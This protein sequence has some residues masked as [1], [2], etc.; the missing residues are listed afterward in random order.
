M[1]VVVVVVVIVSVAVVVVV[2]V[3]NS[4]FFVVLFGW[5]V[6]ISIGR[7]PEAT[8]LTLRCGQP[9]C[10]ADLAVLPTNASASNNKKQKKT[11]KKTQNAEHNPKL[12]GAPKTLNLENT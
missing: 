11:Q 8:W 12:K 9:N 5:W 4:K 2:V 1:V 7:C 3:E 6:C 10:R